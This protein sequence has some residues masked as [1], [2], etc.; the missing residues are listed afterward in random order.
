[1]TGARSLWRV[2]II[3]QAGKRTYACVNNLYYFCGLTLYHA[4]NLGASISF[5]C[6]FFKRFFFCDRNEAG[7]LKQIQHWG[8]F[9]FFFPKFVKEAASWRRDGREIRNVECRTLSQLWEWDNI[10][11]IWKWCW[12]G[13][14]EQTVELIL[15]H[16]T[17]DKVSKINYSIA[18]SVLKYCS[19]AVL[20]E[21]KGPIRYLHFRSFF[22]Q[23]WGLGN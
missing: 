8:F 9:F 3:D 23:L 17:L 12:K 19:H 14:V 22:F 7:C 4:F 21:L 5:F 13:K 15:Q 18:K 6:F 16:G 10:I 20:L 2:P 1:M 11:M